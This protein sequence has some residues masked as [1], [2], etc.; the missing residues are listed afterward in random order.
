MNVLG[1]FLKQLFPGIYPENAKCIPPQMILNFLDQ[2][3]RTSQIGFKF[4]WFVGKM[5]LQSA[6][7]F[8]EAIVYQYNFFYIVQTALDDKLKLDNKYDIV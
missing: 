8:R 3:E 2:L 1:L 5:D 7:G 6:L 4:D